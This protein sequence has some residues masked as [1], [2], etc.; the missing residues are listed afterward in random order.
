MLTNRLRTTVHCALYTVH[1]A[2]SGTANGKVFV[3]HPHGM[4]KEEWAGGSKDVSFLNLQKQVTGLAAGDLA[5]NGKDILMVGTAHELLAYDVQ[6]NADIFHKDMPDGVL[7][8]TIGSLAKDGET[9]AF[10]GGNCSIQGTTDNIYQ[11]QY[12]SAI[13]TH[14]IG[15]V[16]VSSFSKH[17]YAWLALLLSKS[18]Q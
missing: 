4:S 11:Q 6:R 17:Q 3:H 13:T 14:S 2:N 12:N 7:A 18:Q 1:S 9:L 8:L 10:A 15:G 16:T 5:G